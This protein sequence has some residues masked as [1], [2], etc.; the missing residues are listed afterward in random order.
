[1]RKIS[2]SILAGRFLSS[3]KTVQ[4]PLS[5]PLPIDIIRELVRLGLDEKTKEIA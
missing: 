4:F 2:K 3:N 1:M 5:K